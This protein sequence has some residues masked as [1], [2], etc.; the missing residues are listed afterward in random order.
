M[1]REDLFAA[2]TGGFCPQCWVR[3][4]SQNGPARG[5]AGTSAWCH[6]TDDRQCP[7]KAQGY[8]Y[9]WHFDSG[10]AIVARAHEA[11][12]SGNE[13]MHK[14][15]ESNEAEWIARVTGEIYDASLDPERWPNVLEASCTFLRG[16][17]ASL[18]AFDFQRADL[19][20]MKLWGYDPAALQI[21]MERYMRNHPLIPASMRTKI[22]DVLSIDDAMPYEEFVETALY[23]EFYRPLGV[24]DAIQAT[25]DKSATGMAMF[26]VVRHEQVGRVDEMMR[27]R[28]ALLLPHFRRAMLIG[29]SVQLQKVEMAALADVLDGLAAAMFLLD[30]RG[31]IVRTN[32]SGNAMLAKGEAVR[33]VGNRLIINQPS[34]EHALTDIC[35][36]AEEG[37]AKLGLK[38]IAVPFDSPYG[39]SYVANVLP[40]TSGTRRSAGAKYSAVAAVFVEEAGRPG[41]L[42]YDMIA[43]HFRLTPAE[44]RVLFGIVEIGG[45]PDVASALGISQPTVRTHLQHVFEKTGTKR[46]AELV[47]LLQG[48]MTPLRT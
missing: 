37:D 44:L 21:F 20:L 47:K 1:P 6:A 29:K 5:H 32:A 7:H 31:T 35:M 8:Y 39:K 33:A 42:P 24:V 27:R 14:A 36:A 9:C 41:Q 12:V 26:Y 18:G 30:A 4:A 43:D 40:L 11:F 38:G 17:A 3:L 25:L 10:I 28:T 13:A 45:V 48:Y 19:N 2:E 34:R 46:Q 15:S 16:M 23:R 22:G